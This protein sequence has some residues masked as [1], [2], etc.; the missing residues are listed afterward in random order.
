MIFSFLSINLVLT[1]Y[2]ITEAT[3]SSGANNFILLD[4]IGGYNG[5]VSPVSA[6]SYG[7]TKESIDSIK[8][9]APKAY[10]T[11]GRAVS[12]DD[13][14]TLVQQNKLGYSFD[15]VNVWGGQE[16]NPPVYG[17]IFICLKPKGGY[18]L[19]D[20]QKQ[21]LIQTTIRP[22][23][24]MT[25]QPKIIDPDYTYIQITADVLYDQ[26]KT[27]LSKTQLTELI[28]SV[29]MAYSSTSLNTFNSTFSPSDV[30][31]AIKNANQSI[32]TSD[33]H[34]KVQKKIYPSLTNSTSYKLKYN[35]AL[36]KGNFLS[37][38]SSS[39]TFAVVD[40]TSQTE[41]TGIYLEE[42]PAVA[43]GVDTISIINPGYSYQYPPTIK[44]SGDGAGATAEAKIVN[45][46]I[47]KINVL[48]SGNNY[49]SAVVTITPASND[50]TG[51]GAA[52][53]A[54]LQGSLGTLRSYYFNNNN[55]KTTLNENAGT[56]EYAKGKID[57]IDF[58]PIDVKNDLGVLT[59]TATPSTTL[60]SSTYNRIITVDSFDPT[61]I[62]VNATVKS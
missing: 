16:N 2:I 53:A 12:K 52:A 62:N 29:I 45:G 33:I 9:Q 41:I 38:I 8:F 5:V 13:Y 35:V 30:A 59:L 20:V 51:E 23:S 47:S 37:G 57:L 14:I 1:S 4:S 46:R 60:I 54:V 18:S 50:N 58:N 25:V 40:P 24:V 49:T 44:I 17:S 7:G 26:K 27:N 22:I 48:S 21:K 34:I 10:S 28:K 31:I 55:I 56:I 39:P 11:Q 32:L 61:A 43:G 15:A 19:T 6:A 36:E 3:S 42:T